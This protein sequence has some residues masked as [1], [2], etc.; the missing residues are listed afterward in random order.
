MNDWNFDVS[1]SM[2]N[3]TNFDFEIKGVYK[4]GQR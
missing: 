2:L 1:L 3:S 4:D